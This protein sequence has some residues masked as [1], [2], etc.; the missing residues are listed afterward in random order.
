MKVL[1]YIVIL[2]PKDLESIPH[3]MRITSAVPPCM[4]VEIV[5]T[6][7]DFDDETLPQTNEINNISIAWRLPAEMIA[8]RLP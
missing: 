6:T 2:E 8:T 1:V 5:L 3:K 7:V 4:I